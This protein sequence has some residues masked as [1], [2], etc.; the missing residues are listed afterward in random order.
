MAMV[1]AARTNV[2][3]GCSVPMKE[4]NL[5]ELQREDADPNRNGGPKM[6]A[7]N[8]FRLTH[9]GRHRGALAPS[10]ALKAQMSEW[11]EENECGPPIRG[12]LRESA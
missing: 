1:S 12:T 2:K 4:S 11:P 9:D 7:S 10:A 8:P 6:R 5:D 3:G